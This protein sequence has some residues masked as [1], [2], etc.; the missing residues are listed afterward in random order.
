MSN[1]KADHKIQKSLL[2]LL[3]HF[4]ES[5]GPDK[6]SEIKRALKFYSTLVNLEAYINSELSEETAYPFCTPNNQGLEFDLRSDEGFYSRYL[7][8]KE[9]NFPKNLVVGLRIL[10]KGDSRPLLSTTSYEITDEH[11]V[12]VKYEDLEL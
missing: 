2:K 3:S 6:G 9:Q 10:I 1:I 8:N 12:R 11:L 4:P 7:A 5:P